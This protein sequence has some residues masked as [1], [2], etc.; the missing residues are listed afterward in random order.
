MRL[1]ELRQAPQL[2]YELRSALQRSEPAAA[3]YQLPAAYYQTDLEA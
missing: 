1:L 2:G 3:S